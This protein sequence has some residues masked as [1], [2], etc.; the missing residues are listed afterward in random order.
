MKFENSI[1]RV[2]PN[3]LCRPAWYQSSSLVWVLLTCLLVAPQVWAQGANDENEKPFVAE[4]VDSFGEPDRAQTRPINNVLLLNNEQQALT[5]GEDGI[6]CLWDIPQQKIVRRFVDLQYEITYCMNLL[7]GDSQLLVAGEGPGIALWDVA[8]GEKIKLFEHGSTIFSIDVLADEQSFLVGD[9]LGHVTRFNIASGETMATY[10]NSS[11]DI[12]ALRILSDQSGFVAGDTDGGVH[13]WDFADQEDS[14]AKFAGL[15]NW[16]CCLTFSPDNQQLFGG[17]Y[18]GN[19][20]LWQA[21]DQEQVWAK[22]DIAGEV[23]WAQFVGDD[24]LMAVDADDHLIKVDR[25]TGDA[26]LVDIVI[27]YP[28]GFDL[29]A[30]Q[31]TVW[32]GGTNV[33]C[34]WD[35]ASGQRVFPDDEIMQ[36]ASGVVDVAMYDNYLFVAGGQKFINVL[37]WRQKQTEQQI[38]LPDS[39][40]IDWSEYEMMMVPDQGLLIHNQDG[41]VIADLATGE[42]KFKRELPNSGIVP[43]PRSGHL[44]FVDNERARLSE[45]E[46]SSDDIK[47]LMNIETDFG[48]DHLSWIDETHLAIAVDSYPDKMQIRSSD[49]GAI[50][51]QLND[52]ENGFEFLGS[53]LRILLGSNDSNELV[54]FASVVVEPG[55]SDDGFN[56]RRFQQ[57]VSELNSNQYLQRETATQALLQMGPEIIERFDVENISL[58]QRA[59]LQQI[60]QIFNTGMLPNLVEP[61][62]SQETI[63]APQAN[64]CDPAGGLFLVATRE[65]WKSKLSVCSTKED[66]WVIESELNL[67]SSVSKIRAV[68]DRPGHFIIGYQ[69][70]T[71][72][73]IRVARKRP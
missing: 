66:Q 47:E 39:T 14:K 57:L 4:V 19:A 59:R 29:S 11:S 37:N 41:Y 40:G 50:I 72:D 56:E 5:C 68:L 34:G 65:G 71:L 63:T 58:E 6:V 31:K 24:Q 35:I 28:S 8:T 43:S 17:D 23:V 53:G 60:R 54:V 1:R 52:S 70:G 10:R 16:V 25:K 64:C 32:T 7:N 48:L 26:E 69:D 27:S 36:F 67:R 18:S 73:L 55:T 12:T 3:C 46:L 61:L 49:S 45:I 33:L 62:S 44:T 15:S 20:A 2:V 51:S 42:F 13:L 9:R 30:D 21:D 22:D 38:S